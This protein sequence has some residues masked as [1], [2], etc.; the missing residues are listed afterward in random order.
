M[1]EFGL[2]RFETKFD[3][4][5][6]AAMIAGAAVSLGVPL[7]VGAW[8]VAPWAAVLPWIIWVVVLP[9]VLPQYYELRQDA[10]FI[11]Q[12]WRKIVIPYAFLV[13][14]QAVSDSRSAG[15]FSTDRV[16]VTTREGKTYVIAPAKQEEFLDEVASRTGLKRRGSGLA[17]PL[18]PLG[19]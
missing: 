7:A 19:I 13:A 1:C 5:I 17:L 6:V 9:C 3:L 11:R 18:S 14:L 10:L 16:I 2:M 15:V 12:G 8:R 4:W